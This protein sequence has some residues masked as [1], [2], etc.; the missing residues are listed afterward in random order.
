MTNIEKFNQCCAGFLALFYGAFPVK[1][2]ISIGDYL[3]YD[4]PENS[5]LFFS[6]IE[7][8]KD[9]GFI[10]YDSDIYGGY[11]GVVLTSKGLAGLNGVVSELDDDK[12]IGQ[13]IKLAIEGNNEASIR[14][15]V[16]VFIGN[17]L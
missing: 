13:L 2:H 10:R 15:L 3:E 8:L 1:V 9:E 17:S 7:F 6:T 16:S 12:T 5:E 11:M 14:M 4:N